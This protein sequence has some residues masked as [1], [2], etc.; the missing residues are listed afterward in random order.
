VP[1]LNGLERMIVLGCDVT[2]FSGYIL[3]FLR[4]QLPPSSAL[5]VKAAGS[6]KRSYPTTKYSFLT[7]RICGVHI[8]ED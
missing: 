2:S 1:L 7:T 8:P 4:K 5:K 6:S 3:I